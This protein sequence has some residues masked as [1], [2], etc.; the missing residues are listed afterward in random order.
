MNPFVE[1]NEVDRVELDDGEWIDIK[2]RLSYKDSEMLTT[3]D[4]QS[5]QSNGSSVPLLKL[6]IVAW[7]FKDSSGAGIPITEERLQRL[8]LSIGAKLMPEIRKR[9]PFV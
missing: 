2:R 1:D 4:V 8:D 7:S 6:C 3:D 9:I 5:M